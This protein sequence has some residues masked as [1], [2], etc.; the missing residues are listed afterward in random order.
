MKA[1]GKLQIS[2]F[3][4]LRELSGKLQCIGNLYSRSKKYKIILKSGN[5]VHSDWCVNC[6]VYNEP[7]SGA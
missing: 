1:L 2:F 3:A 4:F 5:F 7:H 6:M